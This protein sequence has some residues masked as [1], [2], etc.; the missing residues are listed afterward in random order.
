M[1]LTATLINPAPDEYEALQQA[2]MNRRPACQ[3][4][5]RFTL[6]APA[7]RALATICNTCEVFAECHHYAAAARPPAGVWA[8][9]RW[10]NK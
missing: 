8:G 2:T 3:D 4:D 5:L 7:T 9:R 10:S 1:K 6:D